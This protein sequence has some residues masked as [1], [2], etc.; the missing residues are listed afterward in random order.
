MKLHIILHSNQTVDCKDCVLTPGL[1][2]L[3]THL[4]QYATPLGIDPAICLARFP[5]YLSLSTYHSQCLTGTRYPTRPDNFW[6][7][8]IRTRFFFRIIGYFGYRVFHLFWPDVPVTLLDIHV[9]QYCFNPHNIC[10]VWT[11]HQSTP[12]S[13]QSMNLYNQYVGTA[14]YKILPIIRHCVPF[15][16]HYFFFLRNMLFSHSFMHFCCD[17]LSLRFTHIL[18]LFVAE[19]LLLAIVLL[20]L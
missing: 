4:Y 3:H 17:L 10:Q 15:C 8:P 14:R 6:Q 18:P 11:C 12:Q 9:G 2:D 7:Y 5:S 1:V 13:I 19:K 20:L 16:A